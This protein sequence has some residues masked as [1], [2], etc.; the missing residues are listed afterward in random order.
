LL[1]A[2]KALQRSGPDQAADMGCQNAVRAPFHRLNPLPIS[3]I[4]AL[5]GETDT[6]AA[7]TRNALAIG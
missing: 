7:E 6:A 5:R 3:L 4:V 1:G 2:Q